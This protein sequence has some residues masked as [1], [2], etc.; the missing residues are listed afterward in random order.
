MTAIPSSVAT[1][2]AGHASLFS[3]C[4]PRR[5]SSFYTGR[6]AVSHGESLRLHQQRVAKM[7]EKGA[8]Y[9][10]P[11]KNPRT[12]ITEPEGSGLLDVV[13]GDVT[14]EDWRVRIEAAMTPD[15]IAAASK[16]CDFIYDEFNRVTGGNREEAEKLAKAW[17]SAQQNATP[18]EAM[19]QN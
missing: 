19:S 18:E 5:F 3:V 9:P 7:Q 17:L 13:I 11:P 12:V 6:Y 8:A 15:E 16:W 2:C 10:G 4:R 14:P 1:I